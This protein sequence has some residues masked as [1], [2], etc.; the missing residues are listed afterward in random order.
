MREEKRSGLVKLGVL[1]ALGFEFV[2]F[3]LIGVF[4]GQWLDA[5]FD[6]EPWGLLGSLLLAMIAAGVHVA[7]IAKRFILE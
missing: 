1:S 4:L 2:A 6:I 5:R 3:T 7:A